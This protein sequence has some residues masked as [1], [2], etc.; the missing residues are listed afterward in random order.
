MIDKKD[1]IE[2]FDSRA[3]QW[4][5]EMI[6][7]DKIIGTILNNAGIAEGSKVLD[8]ACGTG[9]LIPDYLARNVKSVTAIDISP[10]MIRIASDKFE[11][12]NVRFICAD[13]ESAEVGSGYNA[14]VVYNAFPHFSDGA[15]LIHHLSTLLAPGGTLTIA[16]GM[17]RA[18]ID[19][20]HHGPASKVSNGLMVAP[21]LAAIFSNYLDVTTV[22]SDDS[23]Y[24]VVGQK[25]EID[26]SKT[27]TVA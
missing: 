13:A 6:R 22:I 17:S 23:M 5:D 25:K 14:I 7:S 9:V 18:A 3:S 27:K 1:V 20:H 16:H 19:R 10:E 15:R 21:D 24:Q 2:F 26:D 8:V 11:N 4:D 12:N